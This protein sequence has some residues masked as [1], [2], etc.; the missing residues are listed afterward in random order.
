MGKT[1]PLQHRPRPVKTSRAALELLHPRKQI[2]NAGPSSTW[3]RSRAVGNA[4]ASPL[5]VLHP[6]IVAVGSLKSLW[7]LRRDDRCFAGVWVGS[8]A[9]YRCPMRPP[10]C[11]GRSLQ[12]P[13][14]ALRRDRICPPRGFP[15]PSRAGL[16][17]WN[18]F[19]VL[20]AS[21]ARQLS[22]AAT[23]FAGSSQ[24]HYP[25]KLFVAACICCGS[26]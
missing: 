8:S 26:R 6:T 22:R 18:F 23:L 11:G 16:D 15:D 20:C 17:S 2:A 19:P 21:A 4:A 25:V 7:L 3:S 1:T 13:P 24:C 9:S 14:T 5:W 12:R 10:W